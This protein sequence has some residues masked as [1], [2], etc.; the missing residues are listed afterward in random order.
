MAVNIVLRTDFDDKGLR[1]AQLGLQ[2]F[3]DI[4]DKIFRAVGA[5]ALVGAAGIAKF[6]NDSIRQASNLAES[7][8]AVNVAFGKS[9]KAV[10]AIGESSAKSLG[11]AQNEFNQAAVRFSAFAERIVGVG[12][13][14]SGFIESI[15]QRAA[16][17]ASVFN[18]DVAE[19]LQVFQSG[20]AGEAEPLKRFGINLLESEVKAYA[21]RA[22]IISVGEA[23]TETQKVQAR[24]GL[25]LESTA[26]TAGDFANTSDG[27]ANS[28]RIL[29]A[30]FVDLQ[31]QIGSAL[32]PAFTELVQAVGDA[33]MPRLE[34]LGKFLN[35]PDG[36]KAIQ[37]MADAAL[38]FGTALLDNIGNIVR[39]GGV[40]LT[41]SAAVKGVQ[42]ALVLA[43]TAQL[44]FNLAVSA[45][46]YVL[47]VTAL[48]ALATTMVAFAGNG[49]KARLSA[50]KQSYQVSILQT[51]IERLNDTYRTGAIDQETYDRQLQMLTQQ[52]NSVKVS[53]EGTAGEI[54]RFNSLRLDGAMASMEAYRNAT[55]LAERQARSFSDSYA[56]LESIGAVTSRVRTD[57]SSAASAIA[58][59]GPSAFEV[60][61]EKVRDLIRS[62]QK[63]LADAQ[64][65]FVRA[66]ANARQNY[67][68][69]VLRIED[70]F[71]NRLAGIVRQSQDRLR[72]AFRTAVE[73]NI[74]GLFDQ[75]EDK[76]VEGLVRSLSDRLAGSRRLLENSAQLASQGFSQTFIEQVVGAGVETGNELASAIL[77]STPEAQAELRSLFSAIEQ[78]ASNGMDSLAAE[79]YDK[80]G[81]ATQ[82]LKDLYTTTQ[83]EQVEALLEQQKILDASLIDANITFIESVTRVRDAVKEQIA[84]MKNEL[85]GM[86]NV[87]D[88]FI[89]KL[90]DLIAKARQVSNA[91][92]IDILPAPTPTSTA[93]TISFQPVPTTKPTTTAT[94]APQTVVNVNVKTDATQSPAMVGK[95]VAQTVNKFT[96]GGGGLR[97]V[98]VVAL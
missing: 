73:T 27:L 40:L 38:N 91:P 75:Q 78:T 22:G 54:N 21:L 63:Q 50:Q 61:R 80:Q 25:L 70:E 51:E 97:G 15:T 24:Y 3:G 71:A 23:M 82:E 46:P 37:D 36:K 32:L 30:Q 11:L 83:M 49:D 35:S 88:Q 28:Q 39:F 93:P 10:L 60:A 81:L 92:S 98:S 76:S 96:G 5:A 95:A 67:A 65:T 31:S 85:G 2:K 16:D 59:S 90:D 47:A 9:A 72:N 89:G 77:N 66:Q 52:L 87:I 19:A 6:A 33:L 94:A 45:N 8:N 55:S 42:A 1:E 7:T 79:I 69:A 20:L 58:S 64:K 17:F 57:A 43:R 13:D 48:V 84:D 29:R 26:K 62:S 14:T 18:I 4:N 56:Y 44:L 53:T 12:N 74:A 86:G 41:L 68:D 34:E